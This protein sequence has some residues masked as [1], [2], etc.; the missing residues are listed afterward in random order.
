[1]IETLAYY[2]L[3]INVITLIVYGVDKFKAIK[4]MWRIPEM[5]LLGLAAA[6]GALGAWLGMKMWHHKTQH[7]KFTILV[8]L[9]V[10]LWVAGLSWLLNQ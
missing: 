8:P 1:M 3:A 5:T 7:R 4:N 6:G 9:F 2:L 10:V